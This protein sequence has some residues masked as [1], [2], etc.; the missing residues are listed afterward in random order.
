MSSVM[1]LPYDV[2]N[3]NGAGGIDV[4]VLWQI[5]YIT[6]AVMVSAIVPFAFYFYEADDEDR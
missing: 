6:I 2:A 5:T 1:I 3:N 4:A